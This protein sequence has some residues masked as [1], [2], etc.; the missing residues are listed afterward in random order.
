VMSKATKQ[1]LLTSH[2]VIATLPFLRREEEVISS[3]LQFVIA[4]RRV[5]KCVCAKQSPH[6]TF[7][8]VLSVLGR[9]L[10]S[11]RSLAMTKKEGRARNDVM[12]LFACN[13]VTEKLFHNKI[14]IQKQTNNKCYSNF[15]KNKKNDK[16]KTKLYMLLI[17]NK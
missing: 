17:C 10:R 16:L 15:S 4:N 8:L 12:G 9:L 11:L 7:L 6:C 13:N 14:K 5:G 1:S 3:L 2:L